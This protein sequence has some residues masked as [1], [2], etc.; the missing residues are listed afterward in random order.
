MAITAS[1]RAA[2]ANFLAAN[3]ISNE[4][5]TRT[6]SIFSSGAPEALSASSAPARSRSV[7][8][9]L[10]RLTTNAK[11][12]PPAFVPARISFGV[13]DSVLEIN[14]APNVRA[15]FHG[16]APGAFQEMR[17]C[18]HACLRWRYSFQTALLQETG[19]L[20]AAFP[21]RVQW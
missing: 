14:F 5:G 17:A 2:S 4:P 20:L 1:A 3:G 13:K 18:L 19:L 16:I 21:R 8:K 6:T 11:R 15:T 9:L 12:R 7:M 10:K